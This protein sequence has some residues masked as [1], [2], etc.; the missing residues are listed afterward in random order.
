MSAGRPGTSASQDRDEYMSLSV[1][2]ATTGTLALDSIGRTGPAGR[3]QQ[4]AVRLFH[5][6]GGYTDPQSPYQVSA[7]MIDK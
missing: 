6:R 4:A 5:F 2:T 3:S 7:L 1:R